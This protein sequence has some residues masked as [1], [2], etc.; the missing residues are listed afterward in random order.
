[1]RYCDVCD[2][3]SDPC[4]CECVPEDTKRYILTYDDYHWNDGY[5][6]D[7]MIFMLTNQELDEKLDE[8]AR[9]LHCE[10]DRKITNILVFEVDLSNTDDF[11][12]S[13]STRDKLLFKMKDLDDAAVR[14]KEKELQKRQEWRDKQDKDDYDRLKK[15]F[16]GK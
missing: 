16:E 14:E 3:E 10:K 2:S 13:E 8:M 11:C 7:D 4:L 5:G 12:H 15:K 9:S 6:T 1:M